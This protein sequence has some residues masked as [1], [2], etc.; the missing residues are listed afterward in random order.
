MTATIF[1]KATNM[2]YRPFLNINKTMNICDFMSG[3][4]INILFD[5]L[6]KDMREKTNFIHPCPYSVGDTMLYSI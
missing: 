1:K 2:Q 6:L 5:I 4:V 3:K